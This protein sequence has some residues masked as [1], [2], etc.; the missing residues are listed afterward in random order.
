[1][2][3]NLQ[4]CVLGMVKTSYWMRGELCQVL[5]LWSNSCRAIR[6]RSGARRQVHENTSGPVVLMWWDTLCLTGWSAAH[7]C[8]TAGNSPSWQRKGLPKSC[9][10][11]AIPVEEDWLEE[12][13]LTWRCVVES[14]RVRHRMST[15]RPKWCKKS[16]PR[17][18]RLTLAIIK[19]HLKVRRRQERTP[20]VTIGNR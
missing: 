15:T 3:A 8:V 4:E 10:G 17:M 5:A 18:A 20:K 6:N 11:R 19:T 9:W 2:V 13:P 14:E 16:V 7:A 12:R 1:M